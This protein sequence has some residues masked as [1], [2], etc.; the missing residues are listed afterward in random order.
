MNSEGKLRCD[1]CTIEDQARCEKKAQNKE[2]ENRAKRDTWCT[3][4]FAT[5]RGTSI[6]FPMKFKSFITTSDFDGSLDKTVGIGIEQFLT[7]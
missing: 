3:N 6:F 1:K 5:M 4:C 7:R 2:D